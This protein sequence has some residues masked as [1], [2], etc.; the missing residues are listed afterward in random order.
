MDYDELPD[1]WFRNA[2]TRSA[3]G[4]PVGVDLR[5][6]RPLQWQHAR[7][8]VAAEN[9][10]RA[11]SFEAIRPVVVDWEQIRSA[12]RHARDEEELRRVWPLTR[13]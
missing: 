9:Q 5:L 12:I 2:W 11:E 6:A 13:P 4:G 8:A 10:K 7:Q 1:R 3:N